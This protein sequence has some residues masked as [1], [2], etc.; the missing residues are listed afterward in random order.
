MS[1][2]NQ[3]PAGSFGRIIHFLY[4][5]CGLNVAEQS[6][7][8][9]EVYYGG[10]KIADVEQKM[11]EIE[12]YKTEIPIFKFYGP[13]AEYYEKKQKHYQKIAIIQLSEIREHLGIEK[14]KELYVYEINHCTEEW[15]KDL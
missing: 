1:F 9:K 6:T 14:W 3:Y 15:N 7:I 5:Y 4:E 13:N 8:G 12:D 11:I 10:I 2:W